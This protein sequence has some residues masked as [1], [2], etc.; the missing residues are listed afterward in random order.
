[1]DETVAFAEQLP[2]IE[3]VPGGAEE[4]EEEPTA[5]AAVEESTEDLAALLSSLG[6]DEPQDTVV[7]DTSS[8]GLDVERSADVTM[9]SSEEEAPAGGVISTDAFLADFSGGDASFSSA[10]GDE[11]TALTG[12]GRA[13]PQVSVSRPLPEPGE[14]TSGLHRDQHVDRELVEKII[15]GV[16][17]L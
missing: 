7:I 5:G 6:S 13:R 10:L 14:P 9:I 4:S 1:M 15:E 3:I 8:V 17:N 2:E 16:K 12:G 11:L